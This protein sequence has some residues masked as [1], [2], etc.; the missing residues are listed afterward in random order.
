MIVIGLTG[1]IAMGKSETAKMFRAEGIPVFDADAA[2]SVLY[3]SGGKAVAAVG[4]LFPEAII[5]N[6]VDRSRLSEIL[7]QRPDALKELESI[8]H[9]LVRAEEQ[10]FLKQHRDQQSD[11]VVLDIPLLFETGRD[12]D[13]DVILVV[14]APLAEQRERALARPGMS[15]EKLAMIL[16]RQTPDH[17]KRRRAD[18]V[19]DTSRGL[20]A[21]RQDVKQLIEDLRKKAKDHARNRS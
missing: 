15:G 21:A 18:Y 4:Q 10:A 12:K 11:I 16:A 2:V 7:Q 17:E 6:A 14:S 1:S 3:A 9:P 8:V 20:D 5:G 19:I 13:V